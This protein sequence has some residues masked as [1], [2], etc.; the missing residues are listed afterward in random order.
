MTAQRQPADVTRADVGMVEDIQQALQRYD[1][2]RVP[3]LESLMDPLRLVLRADRAH[4]YGLPNRANNF[5]VRSCMAICRVVW[6][7]TSITPSPRPA[8][9]LPVT[10]CAA[11]SRNSEIAQ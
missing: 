3:A 5:A 4:S 11:R 10:T 6:L 9:P 7:T 1:L 8:I 2:G